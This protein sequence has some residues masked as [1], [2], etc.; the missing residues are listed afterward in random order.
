MPIKLHFLESFYNLIKNRGTFINL[1]FVA[2]RLIFFIVAVTYK[3]EDCSHK[4]G[5][6]KN[7]CEQKNLKDN[8][9]QS[10]GI[11]YIIFEFLIIIIELIMKDYIV[12]SGPTFIFATIG[13]M[14]AIR[15]ILFSFAATHRPKVCSDTTTYT[16]VDA[17]TQCD[18]DNR[19]DNTVL[20]SIYAIV[21]F[22]GFI[23][24]MWLLYNKYKPHTPAPVVATGIKV[25]GS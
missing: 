13:I 1:F 18:L 5:D 16:T 2:L 9:I 17:R 22:E 12:S 20:H 11:A 4:S 15:I 25:K 8:T 24:A 23:V 10:L 6:D 21:A 19:N 3:K 7:A 14:Y